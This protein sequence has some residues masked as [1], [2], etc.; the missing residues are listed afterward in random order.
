MPLAIPC[1]S[2]H[3]KRPQHKKPLLDR[4][5]FKNV[6]MP[7][8]RELCAVQIQC[9]HMSSAL[10]W[11]DPA[12]V[13]IT[14]CDLALAWIQVEAAFIRFIECTPMG[15]G[16]GPKAKRERLALIGSN[17]V[18]RG[19]FRHALD[20]T[21]SW[22]TPRDEL[23]AL[24]VILRWLHERLELCSIVGVPVLFSQRAHRANQPRTRRDD[25]GN[26][27]T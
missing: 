5:V 22:T 25:G 13:R 17:Y 18:V 23:R 3:M 8:Y 14:A 1:E 19:L 27:E 9:D 4:R 21:S 2:E 6:S 10:D 12:K 24:R 15:L 20:E 26:K 7:F 16:L 11:K